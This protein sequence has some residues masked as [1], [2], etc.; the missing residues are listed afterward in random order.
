[1]HGFQI[2]LLHLTKGIYQKQSNE[3]ICNLVVQTT[4]VNPV[5]LLLTLGLA[6]AFII[7]VLQRPADMTGTRKMTHAVYLMEIID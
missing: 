2:W 4:Q 6:W 3:Q 7:C 5:V 1:M